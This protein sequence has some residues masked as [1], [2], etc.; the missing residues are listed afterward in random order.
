M[1]IYS[2]HKL[3][4]YPSDFSDIQSFTPVNRNGANL[5]RYLK[6]E[7]VDDENSGLMRTYLVYDNRTQELAGYFSLKAGL[8]STNERNLL[9]KRTFDTKPGV[10]LA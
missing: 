2:Y 7:A 3:G 10:E 6:N 5:A 9:V 4:L 1:S 8:V